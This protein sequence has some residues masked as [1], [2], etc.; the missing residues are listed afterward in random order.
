MKKSMKKMALGIMTTGTL[1]V[2]L[3]IVASC[4]SSVADK[5]DDFP[6]EAKENPKVWTIDIEGQKYK[7]YK[8]LS[9]VFDGLDAKSFEN[10]VAS[11]EEDT[12]GRSEKNVIILTAKSGY[13]IQGEKSISSV[14]FVPKPPILEITPVPKTPT[15]ITGSELFDVNNFD[16]LQ[17]LF[18]GLEYDDLEN[19]DARLN[20]IT[21]R[22]VNTSSNSTEYTITLIAKGEFYFVDPEDEKNQIK[23]LTSQV[24][25][26]KDI[27]LKLTIK[28]KNDLKILKS[29]I[30]NDN[31]K[32]LKTLQ[33]LFNGL[34]EQNWNNVQVEI[35]DSVIDFDRAYLVTLIAAD[36][37][38]INGRYTLVSEEFT[39]PRLLNI[40][41]QQVVPNN[42]TH[43]DLKDLKGN[44]KDKQLNILSRV[45]QGIKEADLA[46]LDIEI[47]NMFDNTNIIRVNGS[48]TITL[49]VKTDSNVVFLDQNSKE[50][51][52][53]T[54]KV[55]TIVP[56]PYQMSIIEKPK[57]YAIDILGD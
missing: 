28:D 6:I 8:T 22:N 14:D 51:K 3:A 17:K 37:Y 26:V 19:I 33:K 40:S 21:S 32:S 27:D 10:V 38:K 1:V 20:R 52:Q 18:E 5:V 29:D 50:V 42:I 48:Y 41:P 46:D 45:F 23:E 39:L 24:F 53:I 12:S 15:D 16:L 2:P 31:Y 11:L 44:D 57:I 56:V 34:D 55:I 7:E 30:E 43:L 13:T 4:G 25:S 47:T 49:K 35:S 9:K 54:S 36:G